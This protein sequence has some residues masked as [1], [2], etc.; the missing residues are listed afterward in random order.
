M[1]SRQ[2]QLHLGRFKMESRHF[3]VIR[4]TEP[5]SVGHVSEER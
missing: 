2:S 5:W 3:H 4:A 1:C